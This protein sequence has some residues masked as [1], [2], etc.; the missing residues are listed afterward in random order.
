M[1][2]PSQA[3]NRPFGLGLAP[4]CLIAAACSHTPPLD[5]GQPA[6]NRGP[7]SLTYLGVA[8]WQIDGGGGEKQTTILADPYFSR[9]ALEG[10]IEPDPA[11]IARRAPPRA[12]L[13]VIGHTHVDHVLDAPAVAQRTGAQLMGSLST[14]RYGRTQGLA[15]DR[16]IPVKGG[17]DYDFGRYSVRVVPSLHSALDNKHYMGSELAD[18]ATPRQ[19]DEFVEGGTLAYLVRVAGWTVF[20]QSSANFIERE[21]EGVR[22]DVAILAPGLRQEVTDYTCRLLRVLGYPRRAYVTHFDDWRKPP[23]PAP[24]SADVAAFVREAKSCAP[25]TQVVVPQP[26]VPMRLDDL[27][28]QQA[29]R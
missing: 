14:V 11:A 7:L 6:R 2:S 28:G 8:G 27:T 12:D 25:G 10:V 22:P 4:L 1:T 21:L 15:S 16:L 20:V 17:E 18:G 26:F 23:G 3:G 24:V 9:P 29:V 5:P 13:I 19:F